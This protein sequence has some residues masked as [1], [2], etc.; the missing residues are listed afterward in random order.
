MDKRIKIFFVLLT[1]LLSAFLT[2]CSNAPELVR[3]EVE[4]DSGGDVVCAEI[5]E[6]SLTSRG[7]DIL[8]RNTSQDAT[9]FFGEGHSLEVYNNG[10]WYKAPAVTE[11]FL[12]DDIGYM[13]APGESL[14]IS[15]DWEGWY[16]SL[17]PGRYRII[18]SIEVYDSQEFDST[19][20]PLSGLG[21]N[22]INVA[23]PF[24]II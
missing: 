16:G 4:V 19:G 23:I 13:A 21:S 12:V 9:L 14:R 6:N 15:I 5:A 18:K 8:I 17:E 11:E 24:E 20:G 2:S 22:Q 3:S 10:G 1:L 7:A